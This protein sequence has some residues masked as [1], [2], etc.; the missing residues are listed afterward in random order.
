MAIDLGEMYRASRLRVVDL[1]NDDNAG[2]PV[3]AT[4]AWNMHDVVAHLAGVMNDVVT[5]NMEGAATEPWTAAQ[6]QRGAGKSV[7]DVA[8]EWDAAA[9][10]FEAF[11]SSPAGAK[12]GSAVIDVHAHETDLRSALGLAPAFSEEIVAWLAERLRAVF[13]SQVAA[14][15]LAE[16]KVECSDFEMFRA[17]LG[18]RTSDQVCAFGWSADPAPYLDTFFLFGPTPTPVGT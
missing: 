16:V 2:R 5:G 11:L 13:D 10:G 9:P 8:A 18:R 7:A 6:V 1:V 3:P 17:R 15:G 12:A 4:P 14:A